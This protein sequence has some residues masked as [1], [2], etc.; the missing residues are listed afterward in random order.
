[1]NIKQAAEMF[2]LTVDTYVTMKELALF[3]LFIGR[4]LILNSSLQYD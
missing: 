4:N 1:M 3:R 2:D